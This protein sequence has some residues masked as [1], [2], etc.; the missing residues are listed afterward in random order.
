MNINLFFENEIVNIFATQG[1]DSTFKEWPQAERVVG[2]VENRKLREEVFRPARL[3]IVKTILNCSFV[4]ICDEVFIN[5]LA[6]DQKTL[7]FHFD[8]FLW[9]QNIV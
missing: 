5:L 9:V 6:C 2:L 7:K 8:S 1:R 4:E 3:V